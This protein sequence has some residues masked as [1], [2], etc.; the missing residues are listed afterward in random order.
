MSKKDDRTYGRPSAPDGG[1]GGKPFDHKAAAALYDKKVAEMSEPSEKVLPSSPVQG[2]DEGAED[3]VFSDREREVGIYESEPAGGIPA[4]V[5]PEP[6]I[7][8]SFTFYSVLHG[9]D[10]PPFNGENLIMVADG[11]GGAGS[12]KHALDLT[13]SRL[14]DTLDVLL[15]SAAPY[16]SY[17]AK[18]KE[19]LMSETP[20][21]SAAWASRLV[22][23]RYVSEM[24]LKDPDTDITDEDRTA[25]VEAINC[26]LERAAHDLRLEQPKIGGQYLLPTTL[27]SIRFRKEKGGAGKSGDRLVAEV[28][29]AGDSRCYALVPGMGMQ[30][31]STDDESR[32]GGITNLFFLPKRNANGETDPKDVTVLHRRKVILPLP[33]VMLTV[34]DGVFDCFDEYDSFEVPATIFDAL[35]DN[36]AETYEDVAEKLK[37][38]YDSVRGDDT[39]MVFRALGFKD[40]NDVRRGLAADRDRVYALRKAFADN[41]EVIRVRADIDRGV[42]AD[43]VSGRTNDLFDR[44]IGQLAQ[45]KVA[46]PDASLPPKFSEL[47][48]KQVLET[49]K[50]KAYELFKPAVFEEI[51]ASPQK[52]LDNVLPKTD[53]RLKQH[54]ITIIKR[55]AVEAAER[56]LQSSGEKTGFIGE[57]ERVKARLCERVTYLPDGGACFDDPAMCQKALSETKKAIDDFAA[58]I[59][60]NN[61]VIYKYGKLRAAYR[62][63]CLKL[64]DHLPTYKDFCCVFKRDNSFESRYDIPSPE[65]MAENILALVRSLSPAEKE[66]FVQDTATWVKASRSTPLDGMYNTSQLAKERMIYRE[67]VSPSRVAREVLKNIAEYGNLCLSVRRSAVESDVEEKD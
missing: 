26:T 9:E 15:D 61:E 37:D 38:F 13:P 66:N 4:E 42:T 24:A 11:L 18:C 8:N 60:N 46:S 17:V 2:A 64:F 57:Y 5:K 43:Y 21:T 3:A 16:R 31:L 56:V 47:A 58:F 44:I 41:R 29:W 19:D 27:A 52:L 36:D 63:E 6:V 55:A 20:L 10:A 62:K 28:I 35:Y 45:A 67:T 49:K 14:S 30:L 33:C 25:T 32:S 40:L 12:A 53:E 23:V 51:V 39:T 34:S 22:A 7:E 59:R 50:R 54:E 48:D 1:K 65:A